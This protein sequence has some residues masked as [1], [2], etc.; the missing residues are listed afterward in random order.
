LEA[1]VPEHFLNKP[2]VGCLR[3][4]SHVL[5]QRAEHQLSFALVRAFNPPT[6]ASASEV[7]SSTIAALCPGRVEV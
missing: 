2:F 1:D 6:I 3:E 5:P 7:A 4:L